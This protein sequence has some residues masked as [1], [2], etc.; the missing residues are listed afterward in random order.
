MWC[1][2]RSS[3]SK[4]TTASTA[5]PRHAGNATSW[6][7]PGYDVETDTGVEIDRP[8][9]R[10]PT[11]TSRSDTAEQVHRDRAAPRLDDSL[12]APD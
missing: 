12:G 7:P 1:G 2:G 3:D 11:S 6:P 10:A 8:Q 5:R 9:S 4:N